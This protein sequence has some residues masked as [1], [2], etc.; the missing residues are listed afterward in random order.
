MAMTLWLNW[1]SN[2]ALASKADMERRLVIEVERAKYPTIP[3]KV[4]VKEPAI[5]ASK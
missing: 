3:V 4:A 2:K 1:F 5:A